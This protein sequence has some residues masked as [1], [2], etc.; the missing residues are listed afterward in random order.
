MGPMVQEDQREQV[1]TMPDKDLDQSSPS[2]TSCRRATPRPRSTRSWA[3][4]MPARRALRA[5][6]DLTCR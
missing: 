5:D 2:W 6:P 3:R 4:A 1:K